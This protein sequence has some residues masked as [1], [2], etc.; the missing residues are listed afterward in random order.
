VRIV[1]YVENFY[2]QINIH[3]HRQSPL[4]DK[5]LSCVIRLFEETVN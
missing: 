1:N 3:A 2:F 4:K 5:Y